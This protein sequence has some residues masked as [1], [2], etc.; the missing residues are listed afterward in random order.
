MPRTE[1]TGFVLLPTITKNDGK[2]LEFTNSQRLSVI[3]YKRTVGC[4]HNVIF[5]MT[6]FLPKPIFA[7][8][9]MGYP[10]GWTDLEPWG[11]PSSRKSHTKSS[12]G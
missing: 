12:K 3:T 9:M 8:K 7:E 11:T 1:E 5:R 10:A 4:I 2:Q 6:N